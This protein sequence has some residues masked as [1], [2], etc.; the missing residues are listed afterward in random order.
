[1]ERVIIYFLGLYSCR[2]KKKEKKKMSEEDDVDYADVDYAGIQEP[3]QEDEPLSEDVTEEPKH[4][5]FFYDPEVDEPHEV[6]P[7]IGLEEDGKEKSED[8]DVQDITPTNKNQEVEQEEKDKPAENEYSSLMQDFLNKHAEITIKNKEIATIR[9]SLKPIDEKLLSFI[10]EEPDQVFD[11]RDS[12][13]DDEKVTFAITF[14][15]NSA[16][17]NKVNLRNNIKSFVESRFVT[18]STAKKLALIADLHTYIW[19]NSRSSDVKAKL[20]YEYESERLRKEQQ[21]KDNAEK[22]KTQKKPQIV[23]KGKNIELVAQNAATN[24]VKVLIAKRP[25]PIPVGDDVA[26][27]GKSVKVTTLEEGKKRIRSLPTLNPNLFP[28]ALLASQTKKP[29]TKTI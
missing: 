3:E 12:T 18:M 23:P 14:P 26:K 22:R 11:T 8:V 17:V 24:N 13:K 16:K 15:S 21:K 5:P 25:V 10:A 9:K 1:M 29:K 4:E 2:E 6:N 19:N 20:N 28:A 27:I 7:D